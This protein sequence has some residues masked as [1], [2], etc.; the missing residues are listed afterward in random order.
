MAF[1]IRI[2][3][4][5]FHDPHL[6]VFGGSFDKLAVSRSLSLVRRE[7]EG[8]VILSPTRGDMSGAGFAYLSPGHPIVE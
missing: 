3:C 4:G 7:R 1:R 6:L 5:V 2:R 8:S